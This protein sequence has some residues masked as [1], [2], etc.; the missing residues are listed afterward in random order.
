MT[1]EPFSRMPFEPRKAGWATVL[2]SWLFAGRAICLFGPT[3]FL[4][5]VATV[6]DL[7][8]DRYFIGTPRGAVGVIL[9][10]ILFLLLIRDRSDDDLQ[11][12]AHP[13]ELRHILARLRKWNRDGT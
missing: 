11:A 13:P 4:A 5:F 8:P 7:L 1:E 2:L 3:I 6:G 12:N 9:L 10:F